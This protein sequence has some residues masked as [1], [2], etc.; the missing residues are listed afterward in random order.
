MA[1]TGIFGGSFDPIHEG[2]R[3]LALEAVRQLG[4]DRLIVIPAANSPFKVGQKRASDTDRLA[5]CRLAFTDCP[6]IEVSDLEI[7]R[8]GVSYTYL[9]LKELAEPNEKLYLLTGA[10]MFLTVQNWKYAPLIA[11]DVF[12]VGVCR[13]SGGHLEGTEY[14]ALKKHADHLQALG[15]S[16]QLLPFEPLPVS[17][18]EIRSRLKN[19]LST[20]GFLSPPVRDYIFAHGLYGVK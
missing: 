19:N 8:G 9:T 12:I 16:V 3:K 14:E 10:D 17:S 5:M 7:R 13:A 1:G 2:H 4:L 18:T 15:F 20:E 11:Q 6:V